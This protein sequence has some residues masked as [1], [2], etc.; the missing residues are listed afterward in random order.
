MQNFDW[1]RVSQLLSTG[2][3]GDVHESVVDLV[4]GDAFFL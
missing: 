2:K 3:V 4:E 1:K